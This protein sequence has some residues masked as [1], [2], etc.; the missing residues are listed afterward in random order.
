MTESKPTHDTINTIHDDILKSIN[1]E[2]QKQATLHDSVISHDISEIKK[3]LN[4]MNSINLNMVNGRSYRDVA[5][6]G[7]GEHHNGYQPV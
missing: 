1:F 3:S 4:E 2:L 6:P 5:A 7:L